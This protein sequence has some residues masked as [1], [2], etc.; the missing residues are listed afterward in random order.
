MKIKIFRGISVKNI[1]QDIN[2]FLKTTKPDIVNLTQSEAID[3]VGDLTITISI[4]YND[5]KK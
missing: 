4:L 3:V 5:I 1:E 2:D